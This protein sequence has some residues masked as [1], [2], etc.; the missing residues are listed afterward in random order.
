V[1][2]AFAEEAF[3]LVVIGAGTAGIPAAIFAANRGARVAVIEKAPSVGG[4]LF[5]SGGMIA[6]AN[7]VFQKARGIEDSPDAHYEDVMRINNNT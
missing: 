3:D 5:V 2:R 6:A 4:T 1:R 7:T